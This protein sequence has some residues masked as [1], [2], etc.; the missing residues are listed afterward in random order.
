MI[1]YCTIWYHIVQYDTIWY[2]MISWID[3]GPIK[4]RSWIDQG[5]IKDRSRI[6][7]GSI[8]DR[9]KIDQGSIQGRSKIDPGSIQDRSRICLFICFISFMFFF[10]GLCIK[11]AQQKITTGGSKTKESSWQPQNDVQNVNNV[12]Y[13]LFLPVGVPCRGKNP[14]QK[15]HFIDVSVKSCKFA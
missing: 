5:S 12:I 11:D 7:Q 1:P 15:V 2:N 9:S 3:P 8:K 13:Q 10:R 6:D 4:D 14:G